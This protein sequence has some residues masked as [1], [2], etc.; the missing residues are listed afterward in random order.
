MALLLRGGFGLTGVYNIG[1]EYT[2]GADSGEKA[3]MLLSVNGGASFY[4]LLWRNFFVEAGVGYVQ[5]FSSQSPAPG[6]LRAAVGA[7]WKF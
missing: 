1:F 2:S 3:T 7:G 4:W 5:C 6:F